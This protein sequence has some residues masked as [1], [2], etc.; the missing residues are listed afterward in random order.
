MQWP[1]K[2]LRRDMPAIALSASPTVSSQGRFEALWAKV[3]YLCAMEPLELLRA[4]IAGFPGYD[5]D[6]DRRRSDEYVRAY[7][8]EA[9]AELETDCGSLPSELHERR[10]ALLLRIGFSAPRAFAAHN[11]GSA[12]PPRHY[13]GDVAAED[14]AIVE[15]A[16]RAASI[17]LETLGA[18]LDDV[19]A[20]LDR[21]DAT[22]RAAVT[23]S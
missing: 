11:T 3:S 16:D 22:M 5:D 8:G 18:Y 19:T 6:L 9:L 23:K 7:L 4:K 13:D 15:L 2:P 20:E 14:L 10:E 21:R 1:D 17:T 12:V